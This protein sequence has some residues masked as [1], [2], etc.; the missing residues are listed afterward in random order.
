[1]REKLRNY[2]TADKVSGV[3]KKPIG[4]IVKRFRSEAKELSDEHELPRPLDYYIELFKTA[5]DFI[6]DNPKVN[7]ELLQTEYVT[8]S[9]KLL[10]YFCK[11][12][13]DST[14]AN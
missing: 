6:A 10:A 2:Y 13:R 8:F 11:V 3:D 12:H 14:F 5:F 9:E 4:E 1:M 7:I